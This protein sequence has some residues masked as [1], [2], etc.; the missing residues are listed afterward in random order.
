MSRVKQEIY[1]SSTLGEIPLSFTGRRL[2]QNLR[3]E[4]EDLMKGHATVVSDEWKP[5]S[6]ARGKIALYISQLETYQHSLARVSDEELLK[7]I[8]RRFYNGR[9]GD[10]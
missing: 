10:L 3:E 2:L 1:Q 4:I 7:E 8:Q 6:R 9:G 5:L